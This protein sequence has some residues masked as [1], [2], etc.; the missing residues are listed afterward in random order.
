MLR[1]FCCSA[2]R[3]IGR[4]AQPCNARVR[5]SEIR[6][7][8]APEKTV[9]GDG[10]P[11]QG[12]QSLQRLVWKRPGRL[13]LRAGERRAVDF[14]QERSLLAVNGHMVRAERELG[15]KQKREK[16]Y[17][18]DAN[19]GGEDGG[20]GVAVDWNDR[21]S[22]L[23]R[24]ADDGRHCVGASADLRHRNSGVGRGGVKLMG[25]DRA[26]ARDANQ[27]AKGSEEGE[28]GR[29]HAPVFQGKRI[30]DRDGHVGHHQAEPEAH[31]HD[32]RLYHDEPLGGRDTPR[33]C[34]KRDNRER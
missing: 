13:S 5:R 1:A 22:S 30:L 16:G 29:S 20:D 4:L 14:A 3:R 19:T 10:K 9:S 23:D 31:R 21:G 18:D 24:Q 34:R 11:C 7:R 8:D 33:Q 28:G 26:R 6:R 17:R 15:E 27:A 2:A 12:N 25:Q 32:R